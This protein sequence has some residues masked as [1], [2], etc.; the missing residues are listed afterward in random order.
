MS[1]QH[2]RDKRCETSR[3]PKPL[4]GVALATMFVA[5]PAFAEASWFVARG[6]LVEE[7]GVEA[8]VGT[9]SFGVGVTRTDTA[10]PRAALS[11]EGVFGV[12]D[13]I[14]ELLV[15]R[16]WQITPAKFATATV[17]LGGSAIVVPDRLV[18]AGLGPHGQLSLSLG[19]RVFS[20]EL[21]LQSGIELFLRQPTP[22]F[23]QRA[24][25][26][27]MLR[28]S[29][30]SIGA[31]ARVGADL[32]IGHAFVGRGEVMVTV[33]WWGFDAAVGRPQRTP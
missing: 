19:T 27:V 18:D 12:S 11:F 30:F 1:A 14:G 17:S 6:R 24:L 4:L 2:R 15:S 23:A 21:G 33:G 3:R 8:F 9:R 22:R 32:F 31:M 13:R 5:L 7:T 29:D 28:L 16:V 20:V 25:L 10:N 26:G